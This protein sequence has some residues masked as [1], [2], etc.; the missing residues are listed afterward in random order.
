M[1]FSFSMRVRKNAVHSKERQVFQM[2]YDVDDSSL[3][4]QKQ[5][6]NGTTEPFIYSQ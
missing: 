2:I 5:E 6:K 4:L 1:P 3:Y